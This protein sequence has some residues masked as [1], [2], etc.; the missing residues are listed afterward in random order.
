M[1]SPETIH[2]SVSN[3][4]WYAQLERHLAASPGAAVS[5]G[6]ERVRGT[7]GLADA[8]FSRGGRFCQTPRT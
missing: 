6:V 7:D 4:V 5:R 1:Q 2:F 3:F 8:L